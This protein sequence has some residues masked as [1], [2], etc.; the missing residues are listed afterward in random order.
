LEQI[1]NTNRYG[2]FNS[3]VLESKVSEGK[4]GWTCIYYM[5]GHL[6]EISKYQK[7]SIEYYKNLRKNRIIKKRV[8]NKIKVSNYSKI[9]SKARKYPIVE[10]RA[11]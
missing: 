1:T 10:K 9:S 2:C 7:Q 6:N 5:E 8:A 4:K 3:E 11:D